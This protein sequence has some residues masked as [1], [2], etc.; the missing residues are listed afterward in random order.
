[1]ATTTDTDDAPAASRLGTRDYWDGVYDVEV[2]NFEDHGDIGEIWFGEDVA[3][4]MVDWVE[5]NVPTRDTP[6]ID[7][8]CGNGHMLLELRNRGYTSL[9]GVDYSPRSVEL[10][11]R[12]VAAAVAETTSAPP[13]PLPL[14]RFAVM[15]VMDPSSAAAAAAPARSF[16][17]ALDKGTFDA[18]S[19][20][21]AG[22]AAE[23]AAS[24]AVA[25][26]ST[27]GQ[28]DAPAAPAAT[29]LQAGPR[30]PPLARPYARTVAGLLADG[31]RLL[32]TSCNWTEEELAAGFAEGACTSRRAAEFDTARSRLAG[33]R[34]RRW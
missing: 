2:A 31:G 32:I 8:G 33:D 24:T 12:V 19:L 11:E 16:L 30:P 21:A 28:P 27:A 4:K 15:D 26:T 18:I 3:E 9:V 20:S 34:A 25:T 22:R 6:T 14:P 29:T 17:L 10:A 7:I 13:A 1:M 23:E 5:D